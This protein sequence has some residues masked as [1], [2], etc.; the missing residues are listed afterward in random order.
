[1]VKSRGAGARLSTRRPSASER[2]ES[3]RW[4]GG[5]S[6][7]RRSAMAADAR[8]RRRTLGA[9]GGRSATRLYEAS[10]RSASSI[11]PQTAAAAIRRFAQ[12]R[13]CTPA[14]DRPPAA[15]PLASLS[16]SGAKCLNMQIA[17]SRRFRSSQRRAS[18]N[19]GFQRAFSC[20]HALRVERRRGS[21]PTQLDFGF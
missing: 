1:M 6:R 12:S 3:G 16:T 15:A 19:A 11:E 4:V 7:F 10:P 21:T 14:I 5:P 8:R 9:G 20:E 18:K 13:A 2:G 17:V